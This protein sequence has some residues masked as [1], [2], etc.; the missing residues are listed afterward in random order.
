MVGPALP[1][2]HAS[3]GAA[4]EFAVF[5][6]REAHLPVNHVAIIHADA[7]LDGRG[8]EGGRMMRGLR[9]LHR[10]YKIRVHSITALVVVGHVFLR[11]AVL[12]PDVALINIV[13]VG[14]AKRRAVAH[15]VTESPAEEIPLAEVIQ[16][17]LVHRL[18]V[19]AIA[20]HALVNLV[21]GKEQHI[22]IM[23]GHVGRNLAIGKSGIRV[24]GKTGH[25]EFLPLHGVVPNGAGPVMRFALEQIRHAVR[26]ILRAVP[27][28]HTEMR[29]AGLGVDGR[30]GCLFPLAVPIEFQPHIF[31]R[32][33]AKRHELHGHLHHVA[34]Q[35]MHR[36]QNR[37]PCAFLVSSNLVADEFP[38]IKPKQRLRL[39]LRLLPTTRR[40]VKIVDQ[41]DAAVKRTGLQRGRVP[42]DNISIRTTH[43]QCEDKAIRPGHGGEGQRDFLFHFR[44]ND[45]VGLGGFVAQHKRSIGVHAHVEPASLEAPR[46]VITP[47]GVDAQPEP[48]RARARIQPTQSYAD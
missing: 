46:A 2:V 10:V 38:V 26:H 11:A 6:H 15:E 33:G 34:A 1:V 42:A 19:N 7:L 48:R 24:A 45:G 8:V 39:H 47:I 28:R 25:D 27:F 41:R 22:R 35:R 16:N 18:A 3:G 44:G 5:N 30:G 37:P 9:A 13:V 12:A 23:N 20:A 4:L 40:G 14:Q 31:R 43:A 21:A 36:P 29:G 17:G 32:L